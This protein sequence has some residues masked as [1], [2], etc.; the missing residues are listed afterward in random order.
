[1]KP[2]RIALLLLLSFFISHSLSAQQGTLHFAGYP[3]LTP[4]GQTILFSYENSLWKVPAGGG[5]AVRITAMDGRET[6]PAVSPDGQWIAFSSNQYGNSDLYIMPMDGGEIRQL[7]FHQAADEVEGWSWD[8]ETIYFTSARENRFS[9]WSVSKDGGTPQR[10]FSHYHNTDHNLAELPGGELVFNTSWESKNQAHR[11][12]YRGSFAPQ[13]ES[14]HPETDTYKV[15][16]DHPGKDMWPSADRHGNIYFVSDEYN[17]EY[18]LYRIHNGEKEQLTSFD[19][20]IKHPKVSADGSRVVF[21][22][23]YQVWAY[24]TET[25]ESDRV[26]ISVH[27]NSTLEKDQNFRVQG[28]I[29]AFD[30]SPDNKK[31]AF[32]SRGELFISDAAGKF[33]RQ[34]PTSA[35][36][37]VMEVKWLSDSATILFSQ[38]W[39]GYQNWYTIPADGNGEEIQH[40]SDMQNNRSLSLNPDRSKGVYLSG[41]GEV[42]LIDLQTF[43]SET[44]IDDEIWDIFSSAP[45][46]SPDGSH[47]LFTAFRNFEQNIYVHTIE[48]SQTLKI[49]DT[50]VSETNPYWSPDGHYIYFQTNRTQPSFPYGMQDSDIYRIALSEI[51]PQFRSDRVTQLFLEEDDDGEAAGIHI[52]IREEGLRDRWER[53]G[54]TFGSQSSPHVFADG[55]KSILLYRSNHDQG[56]NAWWKTVFE[57][58]ESPVTEKIGGTEMGSSGIVETDGTYRVLMGGNIHTMNISSGSV[59][60]IEMDYSFQRNLRDEFNQM[61]DEMWANFETNFYR[62][63]FHGE[64]WEAIREYY[65]QFLP[66]VRTRANLREMMN[67]MLGEL[68]TSHIGFSSSG[69]EESVYHGTV[70]LATGILFDADRPY[71]VDRTVSNTPASHPDA[72]IQPGDELVR[73]NG[74]EVDESQNREFYFAR[75]SMERE[76]T[77]TFRR[78]GQNFD[79]KLQPVSY[80]SVRNALYDEWIRERQMRVDEASDERIAYVHMKNM[81]QGELQHFK[82]EMVAQGESRDALIFDL[83]Y[84]TGGNVHDAV[85]QFLSQRPYLNWGYRE[86]RL[87]TQSNFTPSAKPIVLLINEQSLSDAEMTAAGF[88]ELG[89]GRVVGME[90]YRW[91]IFT[92]GRSLVDGSSYRLPAWGVYS[93]DGDN[94]EKTGVAPDIEVPKTF[95]DRLNDRDPQLDYAIR[96]ILQELE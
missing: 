33:I 85:L 90:T 6:R 81:G 95:D 96:M 28:N 4:D 5:T 83:R 77:L 64:D 74:T 57:P 67:D 51:E 91:I 56:R 18:N 80:F 54:P 50:H 52:T 55:E 25:G 20:S 10:L 70:S 49:T 32:V 92:S 65:R 35:E 69:E 30:A 38:T 76:V 2:I 19:S 79:V 86:G 87:A 40:T 66:H 11:K 82:Q 44:V 73:V 84:N 22:R 42:R 27:G 31:L 17:G 46:F 63:D 12:R 47:I 14:Y 26:E 37:R 41:R 75:P 43:D 24:D 36:G 94:L 34:L 13:L 58:F 16:T 8:S 9:T 60:R 88:K 39:N 61:F 78:G 62:S 7:T 68:N 89:L 45:S 21:I 15:L 59:E 71:V 23:D 93:F 72:G 53:V 29:S 3:A 48:E 1:M